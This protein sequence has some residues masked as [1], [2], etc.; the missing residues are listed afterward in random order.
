MRRAVDVVVALVGLLVLS[1]VLALVAV[2]IVI[3]SRG[4]PLYLARRVGK[5]GRVFKMWKFR[6]MIPGASKAGPAITGS[7]D[8]R[9]TRLGGVLRRL[10]IDELPQLV[11]L[12]LGDLTLI[13]PRPE[14]PEIVAVYTDRQRETLRVK[15]GITGPGQVEDEAEESESIPHGVDPEQYY[16]EHL[17]DPKL[18][19]ALDY[20][21]TR[22]VRDDVRILFRTVFR[23]PKALFPRRVRQS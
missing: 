15:P 17:L 19:L 7:A 10:K 18:E 9:I 3:D 20:L 14:A 5:D 23:V 21:A 8:P 4:N 2:A 11:N 6:T 13:G 16:V 1:P 12:L 22:R